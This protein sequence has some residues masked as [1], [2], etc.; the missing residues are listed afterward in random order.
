MELRF[1]DV[2]IAAAAADDD[3]LS[4][5]AK[6]IDRRIPLQSWGCYLIVLSQRGYQF[7][8]YKL[9]LFAYRMNNYFQLATGN[10]IQK[11]IRVTRNRCNLPYSN[12]VITACQL[13]HYRLAIFGTPEFHSV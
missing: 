12:T 9:P 2:R 7:S 6:K 11:R 10:L 4:A 1:P 5:D 13:R 8:R 3:K